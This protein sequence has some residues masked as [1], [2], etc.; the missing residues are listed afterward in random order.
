MDVSYMIMEHDAISTEQK[1]FLAV[2]SNAMHVPIARDRRR[3]RNFLSVIVPCY[4]EGERIYK[5]LEECVTTLSELNRPFEIIAVNDGS[6]DHTSTEL[7]KLAVA[8][9]EIV[10]VTY[11]KNVGKGNALRVGALRARGDLIMFT[12]ADLEIHPRHASTFISV[13]ESTGADMVIGSK[14]HP[15]SKVFYPLKRKLLSFG[16]HIMVRTLFGLRLTDTQPGFKL[17]KREVIDRE[18][19]KSKVNRYAFD[20][21]LLVNADADGFKIVEAPIELDFS[22]PLGG[23]IGFRSVKSIYLE[24]VDI[25]NRHRAYASRPLKGRP[26]NII[27]AT[28]DQD[29]PWP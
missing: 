18:I 19:S 13:M 12:D 20:L 22:R 14:R 16:Y 23:R 2:P 15:E 9:P 3:Y 25:Y 11:S 10:P 17:V 4:N 21:E 7:M 6:S 27:A 29:L 1:I 24:T 26:S 8:H 5:N 28:S